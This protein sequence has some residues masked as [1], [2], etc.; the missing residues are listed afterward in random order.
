MQDTILATIAVKA[1]ELLVETNSRQRAD[2]L[3]GRM[4][5]FA[6]DRLRFQRREEKD[7][8]EVMA[9][10][11]DKPRRATP[12]PESPEVDALLR[13]FKARHYATW[14]DDSLPA[15]DGLTPREAASQPAYRA[16]LDTLLKEMEYQES[17]EVPGRR[18]DFGPIRRALGLG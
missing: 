7:P 9:E 13:D 18:F 17:R 15:L 5:S 12:R 14:P 8:L 16:R 11:A 10:Q 3:R 1:R 6:G 2:L 4:E